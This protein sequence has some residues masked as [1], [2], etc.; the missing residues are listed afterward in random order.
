[1]GTADPELHV[2]KMLPSVENLI[3]CTRE[4]A[5]V[6][7]KQTALLL[8][9]YL[10]IDILIST[11]VIKIPHCIRTLTI[12]MVCICSAQGVAL[13]ESVALLE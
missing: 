12:V 11:T 3:L 13:L 5:L 7:N 1:M 6:K 10:L 2:S 8:I 4:S 9:Y